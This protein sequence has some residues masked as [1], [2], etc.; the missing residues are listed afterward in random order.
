[1]S[2][3][4]RIAVFLVCKAAC[5]RQRHLLDTAGGVQANLPGRLVRELGGMRSADL[6]NIIIRLFP[7]GEALRSVVGD[8]RRR[9]LRPADEPSRLI[10]LSHFFRPSVDQ[11]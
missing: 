10:D 11:V 6:T 1:M 5:R 2:Q 4:E 9:R 7:R 8:G 3:V